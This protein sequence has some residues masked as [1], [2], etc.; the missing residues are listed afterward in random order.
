MVKKTREIEQMSGEMKSEEYEEEEIMD[1]E[2]EHELVDNLDG[3]YNVE[4]QINEDSE[5]V[6]V[7]V[8]YQ[9]PTGS[10]EPVR[11]TPFGASF[12]KGVNPKNNE[13]SGP[14]M[15]NHIN[16]TLADI[17][18][19]ITENSK[20]INIKNKDISDVFELLKVKESL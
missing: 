16:S 4:Y 7:Q 18:L 6:Q 9:T 11:G 12:K 8:K 19:F 1:V 14:L 10:F 2:V 5:D 15:T 17:D 3:T 20:E 13:M